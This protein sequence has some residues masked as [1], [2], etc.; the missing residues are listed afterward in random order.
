MCAITASHPL[1]CPE[2][3]SASMKRNRVP[4]HRK[5]R[6]ANSHHQFRNLLWRCLPLYGVSNL[7]LSACTTAPAWHRYR[8]GGVLI[9]RTA[10]SR[11]LLCCH[12]VRS[13][14]PNRESARDGRVSV[15]QNALGF[16]GS[17]RVRTRTY[18]HHTA[19][20]AARVVKLVSAERESGSAAGTGSAAG[21]GSAADAAGET[22]GHQ[23]PRL[24]RRASWM[25]RGRPGGRGAAVGA[26]RRRAAAPFPGIRSRRCRGRR[27][28]RPC[29]SLGTVCVLS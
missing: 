22:D 7:P 17:R 29:G 1:G 28:T 18:C 15:S 8:S 6:V 10:C 20:E 24:G 16:W 14:L 2:P 12:V 3:D 21:A 9:I 23:R 13:Q 4:F 5:Y 26:P 19:V 27:R 25:R 11:P